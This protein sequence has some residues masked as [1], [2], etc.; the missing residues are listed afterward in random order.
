[1]EVGRRFYLV[2]EWRD[3]AAPEGRF[4]IAVNPGLAFGTGV[5]E[6]TR[7]CIEALERH[8]RP[9]SVVLDVGT[10]CGLLAQVA[11]LLG[12]RSV[13]ACDTDPV[14]VEIARTRVRSARLFTGSASAVRPRSADIV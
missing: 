14:A 7:L 11:E 13:V 2:P 5:H 3:D 12:A 8:V 9:E 10:G 4:R 1:M 6:T